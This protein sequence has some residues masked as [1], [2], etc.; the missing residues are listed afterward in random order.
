MLLLLVVPA[1]AQELPDAPKPKH[2]RKVFWIGTAALAA[3]KTYD[4]IETRSL[5][6]RGGWEN[7]PL[8]GRHPSSAKLG[9][10]NAA[11]FAGEATLFHFTER[12][13]HKAVRWLGRGYI[14]LSVAQHVRDG[15]CDAGVD[16][17]SP[18]AQNCRAF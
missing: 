9:L 14:A 17:R 7:D 6:D 8:F 13:K 11:I 12:S 3:G 1:L 2:D 16:T 5:L 15:S 4:A 10:V 18:A